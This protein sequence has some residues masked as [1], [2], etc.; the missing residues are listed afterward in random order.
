MPFNGETD[1]LVS[2]TAP[3]LTILIVENLSADRELYR[4]CLEA[5]SSCVYRFLEADSALA[6]L[7]LCQTQEIDAIILGCV[8]RDALGFE[9]LLA[10]QAQCQGDCPPVV[11]VG[12]NGAEKAR[13]LREVQNAVRA[14]K[15][16]AEDYLIK[17]DITP[18]I[19]L[20]SIRSAIEN[21]SSRR[22]NRQSDE[23]FRV[24]VENMLDCF[25]I[26]SAIRDKLGQIVDFRIDYLNT[27]A[28]ESNQMTHADIGRRLCEAFP[29]HYETGL[30]EEYCRVVET[31]EPLIKEDLIYSDVFGIQRLTRAFDLRASKLG[32][33]FVVSWRDVTARKQAELGLYETNQRITTI[34]ESMTD[35]FVNLDREW[36]I[37]YTNKAATQAFLQLTGLEPEAFLGK[38]H[39]EIFPS[40]VGKPIEQEYRRAFRQQ[41]AVHLEVLYEPT[42]NW[43]E[44]HAYPSI[45][46]L[47][48]Y[49]RDIST[50]KRTE[51]TVR[52]QLGEIEAI[53]TGAPIGLCFIDTDLRFVRIN[54]QLAK[55]NGLPVSEHLG[56]TLREVLPEMAD[57]LEPLY[58]Q[59]IASGEPILN[60]EVQGTNRA[61]PGVE[62]YWLVCYYP[63]KDVNHRVLGVN[64]MVQE[65]TERKQ[66]EKEREQLL[67]EAEAANRS[68]D[69]FVA[70]VAH[71]L[72]SPLNSVL[73]WAKLLRSRKF[74]AA[75]TAKALST[76]ERNTQAQV[77]LV[78]DLL[79][80]SRMVRG[81]LHIN[82]A[83]VNLVEV[84]EGALDSVR[85]MATAK[86]IQLETQLTFRPHTYGD[87][88]RLQQI[89]IN[90]LTNAIKFTPNFGRV[91]IELLQVKSQVQICISDN[92]KGIA[93]EFLP[94]IFERFQQ[95]QRNTGSKDGL[96]LGLAIVKHL[97]ELHEGTITALSQGVGLGATFT[98]RLPLLF[99]S[100]K[101][102]PVI[103]IVSDGVCLVG[104]RILVVDDEPDMLNLIT[105]VLKESGAEVEL[106]TSS[107][108][109]LERLSQ[110]KPDIVVSD[111]AMPEGDGY[112]LIQK[113][114][115]HPEGQIPAI[116]LTAY[117]S[118]TYEERSLQAGFACHLTK[119]VEAADLVA[120]IINLVKEKIK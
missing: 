40:L 20:S 75:A 63:Q 36:R 18:E 1:V 47:G 74:D 82:K 42:G 87:F 17:G 91:D 58:Q 78:E 70:I 76:I 66:A 28:L 44:A 22:K 30:F 72:R 97:V 68:K 120:T 34:W 7:E 117:A 53:Y 62:R 93:P 111:I 106:A 14:I 112:E 71:E 41:V 84:I 54:E 23:L 110:F 43:F 86:Q 21:A 60:L 103:P 73:G 83:V 48:I 99:D 98:V 109:A 25:G 94:S 118:A 52:R 35:A 26:C 64:V 61:Q 59:V 102:S 114:R 55:I 33:G 79:D 15:L 69:E 24:S 77:Q 46:G 3:M 32:D 45:E 57:E 12:D 10:L 19:L 67:K 50:R 51:E 39:W 29:A 92:G 27:T 89:L 8:L 38:S 31:G 115:S 108:L 90:L 4:Y 88:N 104:I 96:G 49:F 6:G 13:A 105:F 65:I 100:I 113:M 5:N 80:I 16:G 85:P 119:P 116:A 9:F 2:M 107:L 101:E 81:N 11:M 37:T 95:G 56:R